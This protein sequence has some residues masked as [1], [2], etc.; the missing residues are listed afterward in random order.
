VHKLSEYKN[1]DGNKY[2]Y[3]DILE[4]IQVLIIAGHE[5]TAN[6]MSWAI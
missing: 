5:T 1:K 6:T 4:E 3:R 2:S